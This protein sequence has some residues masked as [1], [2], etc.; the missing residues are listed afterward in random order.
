M[1]LKIT[2]PIQYRTSEYIILFKPKL[3]NILTVKIYS[4]ARKIIYSREK[5]L[6][7]ALYWRVF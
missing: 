7:S 6:D 1:A 4:F 2:V 5:K 3:D